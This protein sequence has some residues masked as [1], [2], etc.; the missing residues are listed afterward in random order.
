MCLKE[1]EKQEYE[2]KKNSWPSNAMY[3]AHEFNSL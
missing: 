2:V 1:L 3:P